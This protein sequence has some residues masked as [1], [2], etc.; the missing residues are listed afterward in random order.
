MLS[1]LIFYLYMG[2]SV[3]F[4]KVPSKRKPGSLGGENRAMNIAN[5]TFPSRAHRFRAIVEDVVYDKTGIA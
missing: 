2:Q 1:S 4:Y 5:F 3:I